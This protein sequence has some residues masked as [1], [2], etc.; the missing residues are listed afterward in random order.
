MTCVGLV[1][2]W[3]ENAALSAEILSQAENDIREAGYNSK[4]NFDFLVH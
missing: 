2:E 1:W 3:R 4:V